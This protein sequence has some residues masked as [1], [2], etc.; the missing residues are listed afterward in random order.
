VGSRY[1]GNLLTNPELSNAFHLH[2]EVRLPFSKGKRTMAKIALIAAAAAVGIGISIMTG[3]LGAFPVGAWTADI[4]SGAAVGGSIGEPC[5]GLMFPG[6]EPLWF[7]G[8]DDD[9]NRTT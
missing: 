6:G 7:E 5:E 4:L 2:G 9:E 1:V 8:E 3:G